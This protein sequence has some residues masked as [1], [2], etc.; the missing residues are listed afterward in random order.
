MMEPITIN[1][2]II[3]LME[4]IPVEFFIVRTLELLLI[5]PTITSKST[6]I[7]VDSEG[8]STLIKTLY[9]PLLGNAY[10]S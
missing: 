8:I 6:S 3:V 10:I 5:S 4:S 1:V 2:R 7:E 9:I